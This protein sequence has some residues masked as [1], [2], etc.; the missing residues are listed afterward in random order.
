MP[1]DFCAMLYLKEMYFKKKKS[2][3]HL[4]AQTKYTIGTSG[5]TEQTKF[6]Y[7]IRGIL[8][9]LLGFINHL[10]LLPSC[11]ALRSVQ[12]HS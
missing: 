9:S 12:E 10:N 3:V 8:Q 6:F 2:I 5:Q 1:Y 11:C 7:R 4:P